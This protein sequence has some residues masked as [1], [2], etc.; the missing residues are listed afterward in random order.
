MRGTGVRK[1]AALLG[2]LGLL[3]GC[4]TGQERR[5]FPVEVVG[6][7]MTGANEKGWTVTL[8]SLHVSMGPVRFFEGRVLLTERR[9]WDWYSLI[10]GTAWAHPGHYVPGEAL[11]EVLSTR[12]VDLMSAEPT[13]LGEASAVTGSYGSMELSLPAPT[14]ASDAEGLLAGHGVR[15]RGVARHTDGREV[16]F[17][18]TVDLTKPVSGIRF[19]REMGKEP[20]RVRITVELAKWLGRIDFGTVTAFPDFPA[21][22]QAQ[23][24]LERGVEDT[25]AYAVTWVEGGTQ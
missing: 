11:G 5:T 9:R 8:E 25:S 6:Q 15:V 13:L 4:G 1:Y 21:D 3:A 24:A 22:S 12:T 10:G 23:N 19:E 20:G 18:G 2:A 7:P 14:S 16:P 17:E